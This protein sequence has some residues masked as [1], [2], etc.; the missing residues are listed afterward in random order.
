MEYC[1][2]PLWCAITNENGRLGGSVEADLRAAINLTRAIAATGDGG[3]PRGA[4][5][6]TCIFM[7]VPHDLFKFTTADENGRGSHDEFVL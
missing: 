6:K 3:H 1:L 7:K 5:L 2:A 4:Y